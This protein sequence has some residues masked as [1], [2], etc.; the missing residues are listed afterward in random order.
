MKELTCF[1]CGSPKIKTIGF[2]EFGSNNIEIEEV[3]CSNCGFISKFPLQNQT[4]QLRDSITE[5]GQSK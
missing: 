5:L 2:H 3:K 1:K 4:K